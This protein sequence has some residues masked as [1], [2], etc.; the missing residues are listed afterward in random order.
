MM[1]L[2][3]LLILGIVALV[4][5]G[6]V[7]FALN[8]SWGSSLDRRHMPI[9]GVADPRVANISDHTLREVQA[10]VA[11]GNKIQAIKRLRDLTGLGLKEAKDYVDSLPPIPPSGDDFTPDAGP[12]PRPLSGEEIDELRALA[13]ANK[14][15]AIKRCRE[16]TGL[17]LKECKDF[18]ESLPATGPVH[19]APYAKRAAVQP[20]GVS[21]EA[22]EELRALVSYGNKLQAI[23][24]Y[25]ELTGVG[26][27][28]AKDFVES[29]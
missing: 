9:Q 22:L 11:Q 4:V 23:K 15:Q 6:A 25:R 13:A 1:D 5:A 7:L 17:G 10:L 27:K 21:I 19:G 29:L 28:E 16:L 12:E 2:T 20:Q 26:L 3:T 14:I 18:I 24:R 8:R